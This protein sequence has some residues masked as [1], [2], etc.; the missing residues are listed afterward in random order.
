MTFLELSIPFGLFFAAVAMVNHRFHRCAPWVESDAVDCLYF[1]CRTCGQM[2]PGGRLLRV[3]LRP[4]G[5]R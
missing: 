2:R 1:S 5:D 3:R 4:R